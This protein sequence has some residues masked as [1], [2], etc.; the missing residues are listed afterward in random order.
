MD[1]QHNSDWGFYI[2]NTDPPEFQYLSNDFNE[3]INRRILMNDSFSFDYNLNFENFGPCT[4]IYEF[5]DAYFIPHSEKRLFGF[6]NGKK[7]YKLYQIPIQEP[8][9]RPIQEPRPI[10]G[11]RPIQELRPPGPI[12]ELRP[13]GPIPPI[14]KIPSDPDE[15][16]KIVE[17]P[18]C[19]TNVKNIVL[20]PCGHTMCSSCYSITN[21]SVCFVCKKQIVNTQDFYLKKYLKYK[22]KY[23]KLK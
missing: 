19:L 22:N 10:Q 20:I 14:I 23:N 5:G 1:I 8:I 9:P 16:T 4:I 15:L 11:P 17:C 12:Q 13:P 6:L 3:E 21:H 18:I 7:K 2:P